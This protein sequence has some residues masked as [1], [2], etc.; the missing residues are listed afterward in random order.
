MPLVTT[1]IQVLNTPT[2][3]LDQVATNDK[4]MLQK[5][6]Y[7][8]LATIVTND[9]QDVLKNQGKVFIFYIYFFFRLFQE[10]LILTIKLELFWKWKYT[11]SLVIIQ[12]VKLKLLL[13]KW[14]HPPP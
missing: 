14:N 5:S 2:D 7:G 10:D 6:Y 3:E 11:R 13:L 4:H 8:F 1:I 9:V 12:F